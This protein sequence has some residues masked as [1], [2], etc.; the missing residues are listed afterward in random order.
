M[1]NLVAWKKVQLWSSV[2]YRDVIVIAKHQSIKKY[3]I[4]KTIEM[5]ETNINL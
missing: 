4:A 2:S 3:Y 1:Q 5:L